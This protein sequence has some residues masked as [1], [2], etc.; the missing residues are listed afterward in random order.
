MLHDDTEFAAS[1]LPEE[2]SLAGTSASLRLERFDV[3]ITLP[4][5]RRPDQLAATLNSLAR[6]ETT[7]AFAVIVIENDSEARDGAAAAM[8]LLGVG[9]LHGL[10]IIAHRQGNCSA[11][12][13]GWEMAVSYF[14]NFK[15]LLV[16]DDDEVAHPDWLEQM[17]STAERLDADVVAGPVLP[18]FPEGAH[19]SSTEHPVFSPH[20]DRTALV[21]LLYG[22][23]NLLATRQLLLALKPPFF[24]PRFN[25]IGGGN[26]DLL[27]RVAALGFKLAW[28]QEA[29]THEMIPARRLE[30]DWIR[31]RSLRNGV[32]STLVEQRKRAAEPAGRLRVFAKS[33]ALLAASPFRAAA[34]LMG[35]SQ[36]SNAIYPVYVALGRVFAEFGYANEQ[37]RNPEKN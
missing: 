26:S 32:I 7:R 12:N 27:S 36:P 11:Y 34:R 22:S 15:H 20:Y 25:F 1:P 21:P 4:T 23:G 30:A 29:V 6:Q 17:C 13:A 8:Q 28:C 10:V 2:V 24:D 31:A 14:P 37:Y 33:L 18:I 35:G 16:I 3:V 19:S 5:F 9:N